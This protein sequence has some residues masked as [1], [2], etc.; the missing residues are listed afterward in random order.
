MKLSKVF[1]YFS[2]KIACMINPK[3]YYEKIGVKIGKGTRFYTHDPDIFSSEPWVVSIG[4]RCSI[5]G[6]CKFLTHDGGTLTLSKD[7]GGD[8]VLVGKITVGNN[9][10]FGYR[11]IILPGVK[12]GDN[13]IIG[14]GSV[15]TKDIPSNCVAVGVPCKPVKTR[16][17]YIKKVKSV[18]SGENSRYFLDL[19]YMHSLNPRRKKAQIE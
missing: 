19:D 8:F 3:K 14:A 17:E 1:S 5:T 18:M 9:V 7:E 11:T 4:E 10:Y 12:I 2:K 13:V 16:D 15:V 6:G